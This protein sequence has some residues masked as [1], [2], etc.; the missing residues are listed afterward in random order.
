M[1]AQ[2]VWAAYGWNEVMVSKKIKILKILLYCAYNLHKLAQ[3]KGIQNYW[4][5]LEW[6]GL[7]WVPINHQ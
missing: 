1:V 6:I 5:G 2:L 3:I 7:D 4:V